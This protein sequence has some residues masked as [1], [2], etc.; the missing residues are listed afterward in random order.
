MEGST[1]KSR[2]RLLA[3]VVAALILGTIIGVAL[4]PALVPAGRAIEQQSTVEVPIGALLPLTGDLAS[5]GKREQRAIEMAVQDVNKFAESI[6]APFRFR[7]IVEDTRDDPE[8]ARSRIQVLAAQG[9]RAIVGPLSSG[10]TAAVKQF[11]DANKIV[12]VSHGSTAVSLAIP[13]D[14]V[15]RLT[16]TDKYQGR[17]LARVI[18]QQGYR[19]VAV[20]YR[21]DAWGQGLYES[22]K[23][24]FEALGGRVDGVA[25]DPRAQDLS[26]EVG[27]LADIVSRFG[28][29]TAVVMMS[30]ED[31]GINII[32]LSAR[33]P[34]LSSK[35]F[36]GT[37]GSALSSRFLTEV[38]E[39]ILKLGG[40]P[41]T[42]YWPA[43]N[44][45]QREFVRRYRDLYGENPDAY[46]MNAY[47]AVWL[48]ALSVMLTGR[49]D[50][51]AIARAIPLVAQHYYGVTGNVILD[52]NGDRA[53][54]D[55]G[56]F[57]VE[58]TPQGLDWVLMAIYDVT[59]DR[60]VPAGG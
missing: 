33:N 26:G 52:E 11:A 44:P 39:E 59:Q 28:D 54:G 55:Y 34:V 50:G 51:E 53:Y 21:N 35:V 5:F 20:I 27:R 38:G 8:T 48:I 58:E 23:T 19:N 36:F 16:P 3:V 43:S 37:D 49:Y 56:I 31:D 40:N 42:N 4:G 32:R 45:L 2:V 22:L 13:G 14:Y 46:S 9:V 57:R 10:E 29:N 6:G 25:Y 41:S 17:V 7:L 1:T 18:W 12:I 24:S 47:D 15:F 60:L 30:F